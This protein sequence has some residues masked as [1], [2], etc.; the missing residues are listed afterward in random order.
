M[1]PDSVRNL[2]LSESCIR[3]VYSIDGLE[4]FA[5]G[6]LLRSGSDHI[7]IQQYSDQFGPVEPFR[8]I[9]QWSDVVRLTVDGPAAAHPARRPW[10]T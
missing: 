1:T 8:L 2:P 7:T 3:V 4:L 5:I 6:V 9:I 10:G